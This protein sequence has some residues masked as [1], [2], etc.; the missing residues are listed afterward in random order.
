MQSFWN[1]LNSLLA[2]TYIQSLSCVWLFVT[3]WTAALQA[4]LSMRFPRQE[5]W[6]GLPFP[7]PGDLPDPGLNLSLLLGKWI[8][9]YWPFREAQPL[10]L[11][12]VNPEVASICPFHLVLKW[13]TLSM[14]CMLKTSWRHSPQLQWV[15]PWQSL[16]CRWSLTWL[17]VLSLYLSTRV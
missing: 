5:Y 15:L 11:L 3:P 4:P 10:S 14:Q 7:S 1:R 17:P 16:P 6:S 2:N 9:Y 13:P 8:L 12:F